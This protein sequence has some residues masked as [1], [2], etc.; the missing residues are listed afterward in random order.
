M[1][2]LGERREEEPKSIDNNGAIGVIDHDWTSVLIICAF[3]GLNFNTLLGCGLI[4][5]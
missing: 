2:G 3:V 5:I 4:T 1:L